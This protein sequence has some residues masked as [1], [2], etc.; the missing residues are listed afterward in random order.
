MPGRCLPSKSPSREKMHE[1][2]LQEVHSWKG[3]M[4]GSSLILLQSTERVEIPWAKELVERP[5]CPKGM[6]ITSHEM[7]Y[8]LNKRGVYTKCPELRIS[9]EHRKTVR[10]RNSFIVLLGIIS[11]CRHDVHIVFKWRGI[12]LWVYIISLRHFRFAFR[13]TIFLL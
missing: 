7:S 12:H 4:K 5:R 3:N 1:L 8:I 2:L 13:C 6:Q 11:L 10:S 9:K